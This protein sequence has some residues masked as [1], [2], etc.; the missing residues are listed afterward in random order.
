MIHNILIIILL[1][2]SIYITFKMIQS[3]N[4]C[5]KLELKIKKDFKDDLIFN[6][7]NDIIIIE[8]K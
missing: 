4:E 3:L 7:K 8:K 1:I 6:K 5:R 2:I